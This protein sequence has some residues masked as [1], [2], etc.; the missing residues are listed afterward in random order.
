MARMHR[1]LQ[2][3]FLAALGSCAAVDSISSADPLA[4]EVEEFIELVNSARADVRCPVLTLNAAVSSVARRH[5]QDMRDRGYFAHENPDGQSPFDRLSAAGI[6]YRAAGENILMGTTSGQRAFELWMG[7][8]GHRA[9]LLN[10]AFTEHGIGT[11]ATYWTHVF[12]KPA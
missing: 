9:N 4:S 1:S 3:F 12:I 10:C 6:G 11:A 7:S 5:S 8:P 2:I